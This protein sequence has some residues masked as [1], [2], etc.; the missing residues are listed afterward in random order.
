MLRISILPSIAALLLLTAQL[1][2]QATR[3]VD[4]V[5]PAYRDLEQLVDGGLIDRFSFAQRPMSRAAFARAVNEAATSLSKRQSALASTMLAGTPIAT[6]NPHIEF[7]RELIVS[8]RERLDLPES[9]N[10]RLVPRFAAIRSLSAD[11]TSTDQPTR[12]IPRNNGIGAIDAKLNTLLENRQG[13]PLVQGENALVES[14]HSL[15]GNFVAFAATPRFSLLAPHDSSRR[16]DL[17]LQELQLRFL[18]RGLAVDI[19]REYL[20]W[21][22]GRDV[23]LLNSNNSPPLDVLKFSSEVPFTLP[24]VFR[25]VGPTRAAIFYADLGSDQNFPHSYLVGYRADLLPSANLELG[26]SVYTKS[27]GHGAPRASATARLVDIL[28]FLDAS[29]YN[30]VIGT[31]GRF[32]FSDHYAGF[33]GRLRVPGLATNLFWEVL[34]NDFDVRR[35][36]SVLWEDAGH[37]LGIDLPPL[38]N[39]GR[40]RASL[41]YHHTGI[42]YYEHHQFTSGQTVHHTVTGDP[43]GPDGQGAYGNIDWYASRQRRASLQFSLERRSNDQY[44]TVPEPQ[45]GFRKVEV[46]PKEWQARMLVGWQLLPERQQLGGQLQFGY[47]RTRNFDFVQGDSRN[48]FLG[49]A[50]FQYRFQ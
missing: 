46:R 27:G 21:G 7:L 18:V 24:W 40:L 13:R 6:S 16:Y 11:L 33:D 28:P 45:F 14:T 49:R 22:Q 17:R 29:A 39:S 9:A 1:P 2:A 47:E 37:I 3:L 26:V 35:L 48:G 42:R 20:V 32:E 15:E 19:G 5:D 44:V 41:E 31:R 23:G 30:N 34:L 25:R 50:S 12:L 38:T 36:E 4:P 43:L 8:L 10:E